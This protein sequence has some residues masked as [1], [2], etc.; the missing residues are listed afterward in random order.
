MITNK[1]MYLMKLRKYKISTQ[2]MKRTVCVALTIVFSLNFLTAATS[3][4][5]Y[6]KKTGTSESIR[7]TGSTTTSTGI[8]DS[9]LLRVVGNG[10]N[11]TNG[12]TDSNGQENPDAYNDSAPIGNALLFLMVLTTIY[13]F[14]KYRK[15]RF[16]I[17]KEK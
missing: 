3:G 16:I 6:S 5:L 2:M 15:N 17:N 9:G 1:K 12:F 4:G 13:G 14:C 7:S 11:G 10:T 8:Y